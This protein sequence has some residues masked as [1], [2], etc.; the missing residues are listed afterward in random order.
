MKSVVALVIFVAA[1]PCAWAQEA[2][3]SRVVIGLEPNP[4]FTPAFRKSF[5]ETF[6]AGLRN[7][8]EGLARISVVDLASL[9]PEDR[10]PAWDA[11][12]SR[13]LDK[14]QLSNDNA[15]THYVSIKLVGGQYVIHTRMTDATIGWISPN[16]QEEQ[17][18]DRESLPRL[19]LAALLRDYGL[20]ATI[21]SSDGDRNA[22]LRLASGNISDTRLGL[23]VSPGDLFALVQLGGAGRSARVPNVLLRVVR[24]PVS[25]RVECRIESRFVKPLEG[26]ESGKYRAVK[27]PAVRGLARLQ[28][29]RPN[30][31]VPDGLTVRLSAAGFDRNDAVKETGTYRDGR[32]TSNEVYDRI[33]YARIMSSDRM[34]AQVPVEILRDA[35]VIVELRSDGGDVVPPTD[36]DQRLIRARLQDLLLRLGEDNLEIRKLLDAGKNAA[37][38]TRVQDALNRMDEELVRLRLDVE[39]LRKRSPSGLEEIDRGLRQAEEIEKSLKLLKG[40]LEAAIASSTSP[41]AIKNRDA[42]QLLITR[43]ERA[44]EEAEYDQAIGLYEDVLRQ[45][46]D[47]AEAAKRLDELKRGWRIASDKHKAARSFVYETFAKATTAEDFSARLEEARQAFTVCQ[48]VGDRFTA[49]KI[50]LVLHRAADLLAQRSEELRS[51]TTSDAPKQRETLRQ[52][53]AAASALLKD[54]E[55]FLRPPG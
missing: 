16:M 34:L 48:S 35:P 22:T 51:S 47:A 19:A 42:I 13:G 39:V 24:E 38:L 53:S 10:L 33:A 46:S 2:V 4:T 20:T 32:F 12:M 54:V 28:I 36:V 8:T 1:A 40:R 9:R 30:G 27:L 50:Y 43:A 17:T 7:A 31:S 26:W 37:C 6:S 41:E 15:K 52:A 55:A 25:G 21:D 29:V 44:V 3:E 11:A 23:W 14:L 18:A 5:R 45:R 49:K